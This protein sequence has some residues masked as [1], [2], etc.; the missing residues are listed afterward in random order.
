DFDTESLRN[1]QVGMEV[2][3]DRFGNGKVV[4]MEGVFPNN[5]ATVS[6]AEAGQK[7]LLIKFVKLYII[8]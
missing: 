8:S 3:H 2:Q 5:K 6:F 7:Q 4:A 1:L